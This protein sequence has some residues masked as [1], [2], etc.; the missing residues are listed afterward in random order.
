VWEF[1]RQE[2][3]EILKK[4]NLKII[5]CEFRFGVIKIWCES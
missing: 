3:F 5:D 2:L 1:D 4:C